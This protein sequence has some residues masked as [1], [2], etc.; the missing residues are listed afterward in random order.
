MRPLTSALAATAIALSGTAAH[1]QATPAQQSEVLRYLK[2]GAEPKVKDSSWQTPRTLILGMINDGRPRDGFAM[3]MCEEL[4]SRG[5]K[6]VEVEV[7][8]IALLVRTDKW[9]KLGEAR[10]R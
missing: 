4:V 1:A 5:I 10:C 8:D 2:S 6:G 9:V 3:Y 7:I